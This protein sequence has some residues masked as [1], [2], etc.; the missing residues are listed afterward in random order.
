MPPSLIPAAEIHLCASQQKELE[1]GAVAFFEEEKE[2]CC[3]PLE[4]QMIS[5]R[6]N[7][8]TWTARVVSHVKKKQH[9]VQ[10]LLLL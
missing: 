4:C 8:Q 2:C 7:P 9:L 3:L 1:E 10:K 6:S 5:G